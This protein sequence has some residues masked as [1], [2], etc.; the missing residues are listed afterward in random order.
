MIDQMGD[1]RSAWEP[2]M[3]IDGLQI[4]DWSRE[5]IRT[6]RSGGVE[7]RACNCGV[8]VGGPR[9]GDDPGLV[10]FRNLCRQN[11]DIVRI[12]GSVDEIRQAVA[13]DVLGIVLGFQN[14]TMLGDD[15]EMAQM[16]ADVG[17]RVVQLTYNIA[18]HLGSS[19]WEPR[20][21]GLT[22][23]GASYG[24]SAQRRR[25]AHRYFSCGR[26]NRA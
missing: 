1:A 8:C 12:V 22:R 2:T 4:N 14:S 18:N 15:P 11:S 19:C 9:R 21:A 25:R 26:R 13:D 17:V 3:I 5:V 24:R 16:F 6:V 23:V 10:P 20:D 7:H